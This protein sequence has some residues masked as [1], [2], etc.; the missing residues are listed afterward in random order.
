MMKRI[1]RTV[2]MLSLKREELTHLLRAPKPR[3]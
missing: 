2:T 3:L 1:E